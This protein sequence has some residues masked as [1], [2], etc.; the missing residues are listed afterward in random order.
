MYLMPPPN[1]IDFTLDCLNCLQPQMPCLWGLWGEKSSYG[2]LPWA[3]LASGASLMTKNTLAV[4]QWNKA[5]CHWFCVS[6][7]A[8]GTENRCHKG[9]L[10]GT[11]H[12]YHLV[13]YRKSVF[14]AS[15]QN[16]QK[17]W[18]ILSNSL[19]W[20]VGKKRSWIPH[21][22]KFS[23]EFFKNIFQGARSF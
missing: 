16:K 21:T 20:E 19:A 2:W 14:L 23:F 9:D 5:T 8:G 3:L 11:E 17:V 6:A 22:A 15:K 10:Q 18:L 13:K 1:I 4:R 12:P 7:R